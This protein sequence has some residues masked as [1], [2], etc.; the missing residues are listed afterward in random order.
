VE[1]VASTGAAYLIEYDETLEEYV[2]AGTAGTSITIWHGT[3]ITNTAAFTSKTVTTGDS[4]HYYA[5]LPGAFVII[6]KN[7][8]NYASY[9]YCTTLDGTWTAATITPATTA[10]PGPILYYQGYYWMV[11]PFNSA[12]LYT[13]NLASWTGSVG[14]VSDASYTKRIGGY[15]DDTKIV[16]GC[17]YCLA[18]NEPTNS[19][20]WVSF[21]AAFVSAYGGT[22]S[23]SEMDWM[24]YDN[25]AFVISSRSGF[26]MYSVDLDT[27][28]KVT[29]AF[30][31]TYYGG[32]FI[33]QITRA[34]EYIVFPIIK[35]STGTVIFAYT[36]AAYGKFLPLISPTGAYAY[37][38]VLP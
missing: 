27:W 16:L 14:T 12:I 28:F 19:A 37:I 25:G 30:G 32:S 3:D 24:T 36:K 38:K 10:E 26:V 21:K 4:I 11:N 20:N 15:A 35:L 29:A 8:S 18:E 2:I 34:G 13:A 6:Y 31:V 5:R 9:V 22:P 1:L 23:E 17:V 7:T 33:K